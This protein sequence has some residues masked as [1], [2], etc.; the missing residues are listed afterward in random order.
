L[1]AGQLPIRTLRLGRKFIVT[2][3]DLMAALGIQEALPPQTGNSDGDHSRYDVPTPDP[4]GDHDKEG[5][6]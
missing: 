3:A 6:R 4:T 5:H 1:A 2:R